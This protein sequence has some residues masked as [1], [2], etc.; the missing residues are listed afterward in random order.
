VAVQTR[1][2]VEGPSADHLYRMKSKWKQH[3]LRLPV[4]S[5]GDPNGSRTRFSNFV[6][7]RDSRSNLQEST[8]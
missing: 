4:K 8:R 7:L 1:N 6:K 5:V 2:G 3:E